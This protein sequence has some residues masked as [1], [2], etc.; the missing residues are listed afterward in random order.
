M[1]NPIIAYISCEL[2]PL[3][4]GRGNAAPSFL[5]LVYGPTRTFYFRQRLTYEYD[6]LLGRCR[7]LPRSC[8]LWSQAQGPHIIFSFHFSK[9]HRTSTQACTQPI[10]SWTLRKYGLEVD[11]SPS[12]RFSWRAVPD[13]TCAMAPRGYSR[14]SILRAPPWILH[15]LR[16]TQYHWRGVVTSIYLSVQ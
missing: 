8:C 1:K 5:V 10:N 2:A 6:R 11:Q 15:G 13:F 4:R 12:V 9:I 14:R 7:R 3:Q 16:T